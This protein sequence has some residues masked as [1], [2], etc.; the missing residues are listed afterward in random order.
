MFQQFH[1]L[2]GY[3]ALDNVADGLL[4]TGMALAD[5]RRL[6]VAALDRVGLGN[7]L[8]HV[9][10]KLSGGERQ[11]VAIARALVGG[12]SIVLA[13]EPTGNLDSKTSDAIVELI[14]ELNADGATIVVITHNHEIASH[15]PRA[16]GLRDGLIESR[17]RAAGM[18]NGTASDPRP[19]KLHV[20][21]IARTASVGL[22][23]RKLRAA[24]SALG[25]MI[26][27]AAMVAVLGL[28]ESSKS[29]LLAQLDRLGTNLLT[30][31]AGQGF[32]RGSGELPET[33]A[34]MIARIGPVET[35][36]AVSA[37]DGPT[38][39]GPTSSRP[40]RPAASPCR[41]STSICS[42]RSA[43]RWPTGR[44]H[45]EASAAYPTIVLG[46]VAAERLGIADVDPAVQ[47]WLGDQWFTVIGVLDEFEL[48]PDL[49]R[50]AM[51]GMEAA[52]T[53]LDDDN[54]PTS[55]FVRTDPGT[56]TTSWAC[57][58]PPPT[59]KLPK[60]SRSTVRPMPSRRTRR[61]TMP[62]PRCS[63]VSVPSPCSSAVS[64]SPTSW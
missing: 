20:A 6:A 51:V 54:V 43:V 2:S 4:Y 62:S 47:V 56:S 24:L 25:I 35:T 26:G 46:S 8:D 41:R 18:T 13:D 58:A 16:V 5:R 33:A 22:R 28:S 19:S 42:T 53:Y 57:S 11:R 38:C 63:S 40:A 12:P 32:G 9:A 49:D 59:R 23:T 48:S 60:K 37:V 3:T 10:T 55:I 14:E 30:V 21:D 50:A 27:I 61:P 31:Q 29:D 7:R 34:E 52:E 45:D 17:H 64:A 1:L 15:F 39:T 44:F 36:S